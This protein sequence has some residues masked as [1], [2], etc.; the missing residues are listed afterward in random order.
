M[1]AQYAEAVELVDRTLSSVRTNGDDL[2]MPELLRVEAAA[3]LTML[4]RPEDEAEDCL[5]WS[6]DLSGLQGARA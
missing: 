4:Q 5:T 2:Y 6:L 1:I 3:L